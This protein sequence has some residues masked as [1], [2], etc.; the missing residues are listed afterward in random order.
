M[1]NIKFLKAHGLGNDFVIIENL[2]LS[3]EQIVALC[4]R[5][6]GIGCDQLIILSASNHADGMMTIY[7]ADGS[8]S[9]ACG[10]ATR[11][12]ALLLINKLAKSHV[13]IEVG[14][15]IL[16]AWQVGKE[17]AV[18]MGKPLFTWSDIPM[19]QDPSDLDHDFFTPLKDPF[20][21]NVGNPHIVFFTADLDKVDFE[22]IA[23]KIER[24]ILFPQRINVSLAQVINHSTIK[25]KVWE[26]GVGLTDA[27]G[28]AACAVAVAAISKKIVN[29]T[30]VDIQFTR[31]KL[32]IIY[33]EQSE[34][35]MQGEAKISFEG[36]ISRKNLGTA[37]KA[38]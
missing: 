28:T 6:T 21:I 17:I 13:T 33:N 23:P 35:I 3:K 4:D 31:G 36:T 20:F 16:N 18:N 32:H 7:N 5:K 12:I 19:L 26:R 27:C 25:V 24:H 30:A 14:G 2:I 9:N 1:Q 11:C 10:N 15:K 22:S 38:L 8:I 29:D 34:I 37:G